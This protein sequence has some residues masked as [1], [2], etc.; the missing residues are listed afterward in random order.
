MP[1]FSAFEPRY[2]TIKSKMASRKEEIT[3]LTANDIPEIDLTR[4][5][6]KGSPTKVKKTFAP[7][8]N[9]TC[10]KIAEEAADDSAVKLVGLLADAKVL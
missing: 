7:V 10:V 4:C 8:R 1:R 3:V 9:K 5:S 2:P 6:L